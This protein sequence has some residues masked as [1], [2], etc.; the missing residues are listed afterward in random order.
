MPLCLLLVLAPAIAVV[1]VIW[2]IYRKSLRQQ[3]C[4]EYWWGGYVLN[5]A[6]YKEE[7]A[8]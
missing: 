6:I 4:R 5:D 7:K 2:L 8:G 3:L 1:A